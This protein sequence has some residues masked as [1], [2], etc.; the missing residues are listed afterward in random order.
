MRAKALSYQFCHELDALT[1]MKQSLIRGNKPQPE[2]VEGS[3][4]ASESTQG[5][6]LAYSVLPPETTRKTVATE[7]PQSCWLY[8][9][10]QGDCKT[11]KMEC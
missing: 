4:Q 7:I 5:G 11:V 8:L 3:V 10:N 6:I 2:E 1:V 9:Q